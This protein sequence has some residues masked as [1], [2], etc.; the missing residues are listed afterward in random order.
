M[1]FLWAPRGFVTLGDPSGQ[2]PDAPPLDAQLTRGFWVGRTEVTQGQ[3]AAVMN[4]RPW[5]G[6]PEVLADDDAPA[7]YVSHHDARRFIDRLNAAT[8]GGFAL[9]TE[10]Q[11]EYA[12]KAGTRRSVSPAEASETLQPFA[13]CY[14][15]TKP[16]GEGYAHR[17]ATRESN[18]WGLYDMHGNAA[19][20]CGD[21]YHPDTWRRA[22]ATDPAGPASGEQRV[23]RGGSWESL[24]RQSRCSDR[25]ALPP[26]AATSSVGFRVFRTR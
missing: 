6:E 13:W 11:W 19:E 25:A 24:A 18:A 5:E 8:G 2:S 10:A 1:G 20:W 16:L 7:V 14:E 23:V 3:W 4:T 15:N 22:S 21:W 26:G 12:C 9:P 17:V